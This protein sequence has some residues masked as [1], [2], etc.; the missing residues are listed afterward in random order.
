MPDDFLIDLESDEPIDPLDGI[1]ARARA[2]ATATQKER[3]D[4]TKAAGAP[5]NFTLP[6]APSHSLRATYTRQAYIMLVK[7]QKCRCGAVHNNVEGLFEESQRTTGGGKLL[8]R[9]AAMPHD[10][11]RLIRY[12]PLSINEC[13]DCCVSM[14]GFKI[15]V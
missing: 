5:N 11:P 9:V 4:R 14:L 1:I 2:D 15:E 13:P 7:Q 10:M 12:E 8:A 3:R 6:H